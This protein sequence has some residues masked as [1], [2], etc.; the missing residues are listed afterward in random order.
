MADTRNAARTTIRLLESIIRVAQA[1][2]RLMCHTEVQIMDAVIAV[3]VVESSLQVLSF[4]NFFNM[5]A[6]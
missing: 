5:H 2:A 6:K 4:E 1:H 3:S